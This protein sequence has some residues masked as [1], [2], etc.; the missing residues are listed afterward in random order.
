MQLGLDLTL[1]GG[2]FLIQRAT[3]E[4]FFGPFPLEACSCVV[5]I[6]TQRKIDLRPHVR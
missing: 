2:A 4:S 1:G 5:L 3:T 6:Y